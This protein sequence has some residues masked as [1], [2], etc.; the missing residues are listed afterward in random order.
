MASGAM[1]HPCEFFFILHFAKNVAAVS[2]EK[3][4]FLP[5]EQDPVFNLSSL[6]IPSRG[7]KFPKILTDQTY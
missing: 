7:E 4:F 2:L 3:F 5:K 6:I 1:V